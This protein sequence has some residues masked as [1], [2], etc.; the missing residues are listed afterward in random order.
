MTRYANHAFAAVFA[1]ALTLG[2]IGA[3]VTVP[4]AQAE[5]LATF[6]LPEVA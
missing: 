4:P 1:F 6:A 2:S 5:A 3:I